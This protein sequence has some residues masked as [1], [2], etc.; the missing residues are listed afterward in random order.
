MSDVVQWIWTT[1]IRDN[2]HNWAWF[3]QV[4]TLIAG[5]SY[6]VKRGN[7]NVLL[8]PTATKAMKQIDGQVDCKERLGGLLKYYHR[9]VA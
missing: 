5:T 1:Q 3:I 7:D 8:F 9:E 6:P 4:N 2:A